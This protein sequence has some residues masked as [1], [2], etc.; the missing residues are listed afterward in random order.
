MPYEYITHPNGFTEIIAVNLTEAEE[1]AQMRRMAGVE[2]FP[3]ANHRSTVIEK[4]QE[5]REQVQPEQ[6]QKPEQQ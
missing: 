6:P 5:L 2:S 3:S 4:D 1:A